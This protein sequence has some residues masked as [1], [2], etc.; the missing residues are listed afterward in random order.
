M[1]IGEGAKISFFVAGYFNHFR[2][3]LIFLAIF[4]SLSLNCEEDYP[5]S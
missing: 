4:I 5:R 1:G 2:V 3:F